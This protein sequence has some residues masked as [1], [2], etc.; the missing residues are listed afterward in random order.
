MNG[1]FLFAD[2]SVEELARIMN[3]AI[4]DVDQGQDLSPE[5]QIE[6]DA[7]Y[8]YFDEEEEGE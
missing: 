3:Q 2:K 4:R 5:E 7:E 6:F 1:T 8:G